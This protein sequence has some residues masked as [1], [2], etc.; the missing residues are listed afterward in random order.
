[1]MEMESG[2]GIGETKETRTNSGGK[3]GKKKGRNRKRRQ[4]RGEG[5]NLWGG[6]KGIEAG[7]RGKRDD[8]MIGKG[9][10]EG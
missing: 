2:R 4:E 9:G 1:M 8:L 3:D 6:G 7:K 10:A 5:K